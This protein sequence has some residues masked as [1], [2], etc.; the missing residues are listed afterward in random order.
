MILRPTTEELRTG[1]AFSPSTTALMMNGMKVSL[2]PSA[3]NRGLSFLRTWTTR[4]KS[5]SK[6]ELTCA[7]IRWLISMWSM[8][9]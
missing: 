1:Y 5:I 3:S 4:S 2:T 7:L 8:M 9:R 6:T